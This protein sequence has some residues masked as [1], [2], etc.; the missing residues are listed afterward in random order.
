RSLAPP[1][2]VVKPG[3]GERPVSVGRAPGEPEG[4][5]GFSLSEARE[6][7]ELY[8]VRADR[9]LTLE[10]LQRL[11]E[12]K[13]VNVRSLTGNLAEIDLNPLTAASAFE[14]SF[15]AG[16]VDDNPAH[17]FSRGGEEVTAAVPLRDLLDIHEAK[18]GLVD[19]GRGLERLAR[20]LLCQ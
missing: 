17:G 8:E 15:V 10:L 19:Q 13:N 2:P 3:S 4:L 6:E 5:G 7:P 9:V 20:F 11:I 14:T 16:A 18:I 12:C 1:E